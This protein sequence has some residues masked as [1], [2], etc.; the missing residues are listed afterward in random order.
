MPPSARLAPTP[1]SAGACRR[2][3]AARPDV[4]PAPRRR[5][6]RVRWPSGGF[7]SVTVTT[8]RRGH[9]PRVPIRPSSRR[10]LTIR[11]QA[12]VEVSVLLVVDVL[13][14]YTVGGTASANAPRRQRPGAHAQRRQRPA[15]S[16]RNG[17]FSSPPGPASGTRPYT[18]IVG[19]QP[20]WRRPAP[21][22]ATAAARSMGSEPAGQRPA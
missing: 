17:A 9:S 16:R 5:R 22:P 7:S 13:A 14:T 6:C 19:T 2:A 4:R 21:S 20:R 3:A 8:E 12:S 11:V 10:L 15:G 1:R 18:V